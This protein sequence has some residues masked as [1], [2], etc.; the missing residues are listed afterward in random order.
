MSSSIPYD[1]T[2][3]LSTSE[4]KDDHHVE[5]SVAQVDTAAA[6]V[7]GS[8]HPLDPAE[9]ARIRCVLPHSSGAQTA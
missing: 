6:L 8:E 3:S 7:A 5:V 1:D 2:K 9:A 4:K